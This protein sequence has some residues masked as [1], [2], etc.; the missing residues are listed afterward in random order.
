MAKASGAMTLA[1]RVVIKQPV[2]IM[3]GIIT[4]KQRPP[5]VWQGGRW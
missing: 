5:R 1:T 4:Q 3:R 2:I